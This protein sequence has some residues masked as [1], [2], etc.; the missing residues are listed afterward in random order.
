MLYGASFEPNVKLDTG[1]GKFSALVSG[2]RLSVQFSA[3]AHLL[4]AKIE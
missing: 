4:F 2:L 3:S 1:K